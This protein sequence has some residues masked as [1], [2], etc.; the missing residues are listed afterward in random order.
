MAH[1]R[2]T[3]QKVFFALLAVDANREDEVAFVVKH[4]IC[5]SG[6]CACDI[7]VRNVQGRWVGSRLENVWRA[8]RVVR[9]ANGVG[10]GHLMLYTVCKRS[11]V[12]INPAGT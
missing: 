2:R 1:C 10:I 7:H 3:D 5:G 4:A 11:R 8:I 12:S 6:R 9:K